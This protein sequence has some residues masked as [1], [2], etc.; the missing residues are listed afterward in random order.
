MSA[1]ELKALRARKKKMKSAV[2]KREREEAE[3]DAR[4]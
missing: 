1:E 4:A 2:K 3:D